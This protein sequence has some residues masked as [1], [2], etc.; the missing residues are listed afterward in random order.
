MNPKPNPTKAHATQSSGR[1]RA[2]E[3]EIPPATDV[4]DDVVEELHDRTAAD[5]AGAREVAELRGEQCLRRGDAVGDDG[6]E[7]GP[8]TRGAGDR[9]APEV[10]DLHHRLEVDV[11]RQRRRHGVG[12]QPRRRHRELAATLASS[13]P[14][15]PRS[16]GAAVC[17]RQGCGTKAKRK[18]DP[19]VRVFEVGVRNGGAAARETG[20]AV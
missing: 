9:D 15:P 8:G 16:V 6:A 11:P 4:V 2:A 14:S 13:S 17:T 12:G 20:R 1:G 7:P 10:D 3:R 5:E 18:F 19:N